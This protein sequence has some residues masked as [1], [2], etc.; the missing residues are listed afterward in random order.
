MLLFRRIF[1]EASLGGCSASQAYDSDLASFPSRSSS[2]SAW[3]PRSSFIRRPG[4]SSTKAA[5][6]SHAVSPTTLRSISPINCQRSGT[7][8]R[9]G[10]RFL[11]GPTA[12]KLPGAT[13]QDRF[14]IWLQRAR[15]PGDVALRRHRARR[16]AT[17]RSPRSTRWPSVSRWCA[18]LERSPFSVASR[19]AARRSRRRV[20]RSDA[21]ESSSVSAVVA[22]DRHGQ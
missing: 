18:H 16:S 1:A 17:G 20:D 15:R 9:R 8:W 21:R 2:P 11:A 5:S 14:Q 3:W 10:R 19:C 12:R 22:R 6:S 7:N 4:A 13:E